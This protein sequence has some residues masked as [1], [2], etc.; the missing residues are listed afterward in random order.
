MR[1]LLVTLLVLTPLVTAGCAESTA[2]TEAVADDAVTF[3]GSP[4]SSISAAVMLPPG[5]A[6]YWT[7]GTV[8]PVVDED[9]PR[10]ARARYGD[11][12]KQATGI[13]ER[14]EAQLAENGLSLG[15]VVYLRAYLVADP[16]HEGQVDFTGWF[17]AYGK[18]FG[19]ETNP[20]KPARSTVAVAGLVNA[21]W[22]IEVEAF[23]VYPEVAR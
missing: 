20:T 22:L 4:E 7:S 2:G 16:E 17:N 6:L 12:E 10:D 19:T 18:F 15:D 8:P 23:A 3:F 1:L 5:R 21:A 14:F 11:T 9:Q 13:L